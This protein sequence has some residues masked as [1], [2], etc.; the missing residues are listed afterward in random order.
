MENHR[1]ESFGMVGARV[2]TEYMSKTEESLR[3]SFASS[4]QPNNNH[5]SR[6]PPPITV[7][8]RPVVPLNQNRQNILI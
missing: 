1:R 2:D 5:N 4:I 3:R 7:H 8:S 6:N